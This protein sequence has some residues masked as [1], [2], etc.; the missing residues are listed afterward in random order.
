MTEMESEKE[1]ASYLEDQGL[2]YERDYHIG[3]GDFDF[4]VDTRCAAIYCDVKEIQDSDIESVEGIDAHLHLRGD[5]RKLRNKYKGKKLDVPVVLVAMNY[6][7]NYFTGLTVGRALMGDVGITFDR[8]TLKAGKPLHHIQRGNAVFTRNQNTSISG[9]FVFDRV[10]G[11]HCFFDNPYSEN[12]MPRDVF[13]NLRFVAL[14]RSTI[15]Q[16]LIDLGNI[17]F[18][19]VD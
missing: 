10:N 6:S 7:S 19:N 4:C 14:S 17:M 13:T 18:W 1:F 16:E 5:I 12:P 3:P 8:N 9:V 2:V 15:G 11:R